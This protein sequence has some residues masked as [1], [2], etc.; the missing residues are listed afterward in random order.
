MNL[1]QMTDNLKDNAKVTEELMGALE[2]VLVSIVGRV[3]CWLAPL[4]SAVLVARSAGE[5]F[6]LAGGWSIVIALVLELVGLVTSNL[7]LTAKEWNQTK[8]KSDPL[9]NEPLALG[10]MIFY[11]VVAFLLI[12]AVELP[13]VMNGGNLAGLTALL[14]PGLSA[15]GVIALNERVAHFRRVSDVEAD[16]KKRSNRQKNRYVPEPKA[17]R[18]AYGKFTSPETIEQA[19]AILTDNPDISGAELGRKLGKSDGLGRKLRKGLLAE[20][21]DNGRGT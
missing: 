18:T 8:R 2:A 17:V 20:I 21:S 11:F 5:V 1:Q 6:D 3:A 19:R 7:W 9:A 14:F 12:L 15:V 4:P 16:K 10:L 13:N